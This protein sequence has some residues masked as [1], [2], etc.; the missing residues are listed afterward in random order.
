MNTNKVTSQECLTYVIFSLNRF[1]FFQV[2]VVAMFHL[3][4][5][6][7]RCI[8]LDTQTFNKLTLLQLVILQ[9]STRIET[10]FTFHLQARHQ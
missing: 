4:L 1:D 3:V 7:S 10:I 5:L 9:F 6:F 8:Q 2:L